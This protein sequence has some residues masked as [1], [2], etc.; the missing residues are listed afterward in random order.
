[1]L[2]DPSEVGWFM[3]RM[4]VLFLVLSLAI[5]SSAEHQQNTV[6]SHSRPKGP[7]P[8]PGY[9]VMDPFSLNVRYS[10]G[11]EPVNV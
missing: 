5:I 8:C 6:S 11:L 10:R 9:D 7:R 3:K 4:S 2:G 1:M